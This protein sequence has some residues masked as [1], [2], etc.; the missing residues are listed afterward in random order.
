MH[1]KQR[2]L[3]FF[4]V[5]VV[6]VF[7]F[8]WRPHSSGRCLLF[9][10]CVV[11]VVGAVENGIFGDSFDW[12]VS[13]WNEFWHAPLFYLFG[14]VN[15]QRKTVDSFVFLVVVVR[16]RGEKNDSS[17]VCMNLTYVQCSSVERM[18]FINRWVKLHTNDQNVEH[19]KFIVV[20]FGPHLLVYGLIF[21][22]S[23]LSLWMIYCP[24][25]RTVLH[26]RQCDCVVFSSNQKRHQ[27]PL[28]P[29]GRG[30]IAFVSKFANCKHF[31]MN[32]YGLVVKGRWPINQLD[33][34]GA[35]QA[36]SEI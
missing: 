19:I 5:V 18:L 7:F 24:Y 26:R 13:N 6:D 2:L 20:M 14:C 12:N 17:T 36:R 34:I 28:K 25:I 4:V 3:C 23:F 22:S 10:W 30:K 16:K 1:I 33:A 31:E 27:N 29:L 9:Y 11:F 21:F 35:N 8:L 32:I 15:K